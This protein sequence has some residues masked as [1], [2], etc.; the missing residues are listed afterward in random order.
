MR[1]LVAASLRACVER[2][3]GRLA[4]WGPDGF[5]PGS[6]PGVRP[7]GA[8][9]GVAHDA[10]GCGG[11]ACRCGRA[12]RVRERAR[13]EGAASAGGGSRRDQRRPGDAGAI[14]APVRASVHRARRAEPPPSRGGGVPRAGGGRGREGRAAE[15][16]APARERRELSADRLRADARDGAG[17]RRGARALRSRAAPGR[18]GAG[19]RARYG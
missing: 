16:G 6:R 15:R 13:G 3:P 7:R 18:P 1:E 10:C 19:P 8:R 2:S 5:A 12:V 14:P 17:P 11:G 4:A 9:S